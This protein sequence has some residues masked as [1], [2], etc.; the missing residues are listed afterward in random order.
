MPIRVHAV[1]TPTAAHPHPRAPQLTAAHSCAQ[2][3]ARPALPCFFHPRPL[4]GSGQRRRRR[5]SARP[6]RPPHRAPRVRPRGVGCHGMDSRRTER[7]RSAHARDRCSAD[8]S[9]GPPS[10]RD[11]ESVLPRSGA[12][13]CLGELSGYIAIGLFGDGRDG[14]GSS[15]FCFH[16]DGL[17]GWRQT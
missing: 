17:D 1:H 15:R 2:L 8:S 7:D 10:D 11:R 6:L 12:T 16:G 9:R 14:G 3:P 4:R 5:T 13:T